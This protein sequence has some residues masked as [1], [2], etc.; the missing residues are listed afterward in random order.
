MAHYERELALAAPIEQVFAVLV[1]VAGWSDWDPS[2]R[3]SV[4]RDEGPPSVGSRYDVTV[5]FYGKAIEQV[6]EITE[7]D[8]PRRLVVATEGR[9]QGRW[10]FELSSGTDATTVRWDA[11][12]G[13]KGMT[14][15]LDRGL[16]V[17]FAG[18]GDNAVEG[19]TRRLA[20]T[21]AG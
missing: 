4:A 21:G 17:A 16:G 10:V 2:I 12:I 5:G 11:T 7:L 14:R 19:L 3:R 13:L 9:A 1:D 8:E 20:E 6:H 18:L 15:L